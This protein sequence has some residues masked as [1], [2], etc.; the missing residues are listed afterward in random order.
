MQTLMAFSLEIVPLLLLLTGGPNSMGFISTAP[1]IAGFKTTTNCTSYCIPLCTF[2]WSVKGVVVKGSTLTWMPDGLD[3]V[4]E[5]TCTARN[6]ETAKA[7]KRTFTVEVRN[8]VSV[9]INP[10]NH[11]PS[12]N[13]SLGLVCDGSVQGLPVEWYSN[14]RR[15]TPRKGLSLMKDNTILY[16]DSLVPLDAGF[17]RCKATMPT[18]YRGTAFSLGY[19]LNFDPWNVTING[20][21]AVVP[22]VQSIFSCLTSCTLNVDCTIR[23]AFK[24]GFPHFSTY[25]NVLKWT[26]SIQ[27]SFQNL[28]CMVENTAAQRSVQVT[29]MVE[30]KGMEMVIDL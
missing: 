12:L 27:E 8:Q 5:L 4:V 7:F 25:K 11:L 10:E 30:V 17:Y 1:S 28:T 2:S 9:Q 29:K 21:D 16:F 18:F 23:W 20:P 22:G 13:Q 15:V 6:P 24:G 3:S 26:P 19:L 14:G